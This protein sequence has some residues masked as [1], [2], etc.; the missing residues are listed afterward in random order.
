MIE[1]RWH[2]RGGQGVVTA[3]EILA[4][5][6]LLEGKFVQHWPMFGPERRGAP[7]NA[8]TRIDEEPID[9]H[10]G[11]Y[12]PDIV[13]VIDPT[14]LANVESITEGIKENALI[15]VNASKINDELIR[16]VKKLNLKLYAVDAYT[17]AID[18]FNR[19]FYNTPMLGALVKAS[20]IVSLQSIY[21][22][23]KEKFKG[24]IVEKNIEAIRRAYEE[25]KKI[26]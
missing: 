14:L 13:V 19:P 16:E 23:V 21:K 12:N 25:V 24:N 17:I 4:K 15:V 7:V 2:G 9:V 8:F 20:S 26:E 6:A 5:A 1:I 22:V 10:F 18:I 11:V 3:S